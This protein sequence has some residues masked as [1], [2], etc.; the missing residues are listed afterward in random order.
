ML[1]INGAIYGAIFAA[2][3]RLV[4]GE[5]EV[6][7]RLRER[8]DESR[9]K[10]EELSDLVGDLSPTRPGTWADFAGRL[11]DHASGAPRRYDSPNEA[12]RKTGFDM[13]LDVP[14]AVVKQLIRRHEGRLLYR[15]DSQELV[16]VELDEQIHVCV[17]IDHRPRGEA[18]LHYRSAH[19]E[20]GAVL[21]ALGDDLWR[22]QQ[23]LHFDASAGKLTM[24]SV[25][26]ERHQYFGEHLDLIERWRQFRRRGIRRNIL[27]QGPP[28]CGKTTLCCHAAR[29]LGDRVVIASFGLIG[30]L[31]LHKWLLLLELVNPDVLVIDDID[32]L[33]AGGRHHRHRGG[34]FG[35][36]DGKLAFFEEGLCEIPLVLVTSNDHTRLPGALRR[37]GRIDRIISFDEPEDAMR[38]KIIG[39]LADREGVAIPP[40]EMDR[41]LEAFD[42]FS[43]AHVVEILRRARVCGW[44]DSRADDHSFLLQ[45]EFASVGEWL[46]LH[47]FRQIQLDADFVLEALIERCDVELVH[48]EERVR[49]FRIVLPNGARL[50]FERSDHGLHSGRT[51][52]YREADG[53]QRLYDA[54]GRC[55]WRDRKVVLLDDVGDGGTSCRTLPVKE[56]RYYGSLTECLEQWQA[57]RRDGYRR[58]ILLQGPPGCGKS[59]FC[60]HA[61]AELAERTMLLTPEYYEK[62]RCGTWAGVVDL[63]QP[64][65][66]IVDDVDRV[67]QHSLESK[68]RLFE[69][70]YCDIP[71]VLFTTNDHQKLPAPM[72]RPGR[73]DQI[74]EVEPP[75]KELRW[76]LID[77][78][79]RREGLDEVPDEHLEML[80]DVLTEQSTAHL[81]EALRRARVCGWKRCLSPVDE[82]TTFATGD[83]NDEELDSFANFGGC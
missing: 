9:D 63:L 26:L 18:M 82:D 43:T 55:F 24:R 6:S 81:V 72:R 74:L 56:A 31:D 57:F 10:V 78:M 38:R 11:M 71:F 67:G 3:S 30:E 8:L 41:L 42:K 73:I 16:V 19:C 29:E 70:G 35:N 17:E 68:L 15:E 69:E 52:Y 47:G 46:R 27:L 40:G 58:S 36:L 66:V 51:T 61:A 23:C 7:E 12:R 80:D 76:K 28:G 34:R 48:E 50:C 79:A 44:R 62:V 32:R 2:G 45:H 54:I 20:R 4:H 37:P 59:T 60:L 75:S 49:L 21:K 83:D 65:M 14:I 1:P 53:R 39:E 77:E 33:G 25:E 22:A 5:V 64:D 13:V